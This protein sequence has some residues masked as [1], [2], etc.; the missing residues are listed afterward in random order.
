MTGAVDRMSDPLEKRRLFVTG[1]S[2]CLG[3]RLCRWFLRRGWDVTGLIRET[4]D[5][6]LVEG[7]EGLALARADLFETEKYAAHLGPDTIAVHSAAALHLDMNKRENVDRL[8]R[9]NVEGTRAVI[10]TCRRRGVRRFI[11]VSSIAAMG[12]FH[13]GERDETASCSPESP[14]GRSKRAGEEAA[15]AAHGPGFSVTVLRP[16][17]IYGPGDRGTVL[18]MIRY[19]HRGT[20]RFIGTG[21]NE[22]TL[23]AVDNVCAAVQAVIEAEGAAGQI[24]I[25]VDREK[26]SLREIAGSIAAGLGVHLNRVRVPLPVGLAIGFAGDAVT[27]AT[28]IPVPIGWQNVRNLTASATYSVAKLERETGYRQPVAFP[29]GIGEEIEWYLAGKGSMERRRR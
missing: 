21:R 5:T 25:V 8:F 28:G 17:V 10:E 16:G 13:G 29:E 26:R 19:I 24:Y 20:F 11:H 6:S 15:I 9:V 22:K 14:Y 27:R 18:K 1:A 12:D 2:G 3:A 7:L 4:S 23:V